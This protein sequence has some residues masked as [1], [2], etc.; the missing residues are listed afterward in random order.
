[1]KMMMDSQKVQNLQVFLFSLNYRNNVESTIKS[2]IIVAGINDMTMSRSSSG[3]G[4]GDPN[5]QRLALD[6]LIVHP[7]FSHFYPEFHND[8]AVVR[9]A[10]PGFEWGPSV[11]PACLSSKNNLMPLS[12]GVV[13]G[14]G[15]SQSQDGDNNSGNE[16]GKSLQI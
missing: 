7:Q 9:V 16:N 3:G 11:Q 6:K 14:W 1:M 13:A 4:I 10:S 2:T 5:E 15:I 12:W 8:I